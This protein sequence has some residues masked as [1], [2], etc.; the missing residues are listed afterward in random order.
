M[1]GRED[2]VA[3]MRPI[4]YCIVPRELASVLHEV[5]RRHFLY[6]PGIEVIVERRAG[7]RRSP[8]ERRSS[9]DAR[10]GVDRRAIRGSAGRRA[11]ERR[12]TLVGVDQ[13]QL[14]RK[15]RRFAAE[16]VFVERLEPATPRAEDLDS[17]RIVARI[18]GGE[19]EAFSLL[20][21]R[22]YDRVYSYL[23]IVLGDVHEAEDGAQQVF[24]NVLRALP[25]YEPRAPFRGWLFVIV[26]NHALALLKRRSRVEL[27]DPDLLSNDYEAETSVEFFDRSALGWI[28]DRELLMFVE[29]LPLPQRQVLLLRYFADL[30]HA[31]IARILGRSSEDVR[32]LAHRALNQLRRRLTT[33]GH[34]ASRTR[35]APVVRCRDQ[36]F[37]LRRR[38][39]ALMR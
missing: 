16:I 37:I 19:A 29:R 3:P 14:P 7:D 22:Y 6:E 2:T 35:R 33:V 34:A 30:P 13:P 39:F 24:V 8:G 10:P 9:L 12:A 17:D 11:G 36:A 26:R 18:Q 28:T 21:A 5:L 20:Y 4:V 25:E 38:R 15:A 31:E 23:R 32:I 1:R 27:V